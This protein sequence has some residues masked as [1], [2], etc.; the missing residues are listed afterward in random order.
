ML[1]WDLSEDCRL[2]VL[3]DGV[4]PGS[5]RRCNASTPGQRIPSPLQ[6]VET[7]RRHDGQVEV[8]YIEDMAHNAYFGPLRQQ[9]AT[10]AS[11]QTYGAS[12][13]ATDAA[14]ERFFSL[15]RQFIAAQA[16]RP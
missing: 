15:M 9:R 16:L 14:R 7:V 8:V 11:G 6:W 2:N 10:W 12:L 1:R 5:A 3:V 4:P 13:G